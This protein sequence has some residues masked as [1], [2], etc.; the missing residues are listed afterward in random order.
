MKNENNEINESS[1]I[2]KLVNV[3]HENSEEDAKVHLPS[4]ASNNILTL[5]PVES[6]EI[7]I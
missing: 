7:H 4:G 1:W 5:N 6:K 3:M 2:V